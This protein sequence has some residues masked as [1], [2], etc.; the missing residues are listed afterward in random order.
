MNLA[1]SSLVLENLRFFEVK[2]QEFTDRAFSP[3]VIKKGWH[4]NFYPPLV[5]ESLQP[6]TGGMNIRKK[7]VFCGAGA[8]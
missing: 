1:F 3:V 8:S 4:S 6:W 7:N 2:N 5:R